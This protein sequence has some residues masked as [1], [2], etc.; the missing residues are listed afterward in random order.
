MPDF[1]IQLASEQYFARI[2][3][4]ALML[5]GNPWDADDLAQETFLTAARSAERFEGRS[6]PFTWLYGVLLN[7]ERRRRRRRGLD[8][9][10][11]RVLWDQ[12]TDEPAAPA[13]DVAVEV[14]EWRRSL[15]SLVA[16]LP[17]AQRDV[18]VLRFSEHLAYQDIAEVLE[19]RLGT[20][21]SRIFH[22]LAGLRELTGGQADQSVLLPIPKQASS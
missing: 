10:K 5:T 6:Q 1:D 15:W 8:R 11:L 22:A 17:D 3:R 21:K 20:V 4:A 19:C 7:M 13:A 16:Q 14:A 2:R 18:L 12:E 9:R